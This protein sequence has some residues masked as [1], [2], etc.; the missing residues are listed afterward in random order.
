MKEDVY[1]AAVVG[2][3]VQSQMGRVVTSL[4]LLNSHYHWALR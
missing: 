2:I 1:F 3:N 4:D